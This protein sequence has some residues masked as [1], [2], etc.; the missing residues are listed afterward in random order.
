MALKRKITHKKGKRRTA[1]GGDLPA[2]NQ[3]Q[4]APQAPPA[5]NQSAV[6]APNAAPVA[7]QS[8][9]KAPNAA[10][11]ANKAPAMNDTNSFFQA[12]LNQDYDKVKE[13]LKK[14]PN[15]NVQDT[16]GNNALHY[17]LNVKNPAMIDLILS[18]NSYNAPYRGVVKPGLDIDKANKD[19]ITP[20]LGAYILD[21]YDY[22]KKLLDACVNINKQ[23][24]NGLTILMKI[25]SLKNNIK[26]ITIINMLRGPGYADQSIRDKRGNRAG[27]YAFKYGEKEITENPSLSDE[28]KEELQEIVDMLDSDYHFTSSHKNRYEDKC[29]FRKGPPRRRGGDYNFYN[30]PSRSLIEAVEREDLEGVKKFLA[31]N[32]TDVNQKDDRGMTALHYAVDKNNESIVKELLSYSGEGKTLNIDVLDNY[33][34]TPLCI[35]YLSANH[36]MITLL[37]ANSANINIQDKKGKTILMKLLSSTKPNMAMIN[38]IKGQGALVNLK[39]INGETALDYAKKQL[40]RANNSQR[41]AMEKLVASMEGQRAEGQMGGRR[42]KK[43]IT[44][45]RLKK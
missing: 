26:P 21:N 42:K 10:P 30:G 15:I 16:S 36:D 34:R 13:F 9:V 29:G 32:S 3:G 5:A 31:D 7:N 22:A 25:F 37:I 12:I 19:G 38:L 2:T 14:L 24:Q 33:D 1:Y 40:A 20:L 6:K 43:N 39:D 8:A 45:R 27:D 23:D 11:V 28:R 18:Y 4:V 35:A 44:R 17:A 41:N